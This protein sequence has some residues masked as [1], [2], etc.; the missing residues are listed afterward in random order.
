MLPMNNKLDF[1]PHT[2]QWDTMNRDEFLYWSTYGSVSTKLIKRWNLNAG[3]S[4]RVLD[5]GTGLGRNAR[6]MARYGMDVYA[7]DIDTDVLKQANEIT[8]KEALNV[9]FVSGD[10]RQMPFDNDFFD[11]VYAENVLSLT[12]FA[13]LK[14]TLGEIYRTLK[15][16]GEAFLVIA[17]KSSPTI[18]NAQMIDENTVLISQQYGTNTGVATFVDDQT[19]KTCLGKLEIIDKYGAIHGYFPETYRHMILTKKIR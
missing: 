3:G 13:G 1:L 6:K 19:L 9:N 17:D 12:S 10:M 7:L 2:W 18:Q 5:L 8:N 4:A 11:A 16:N 15:K 14:Q